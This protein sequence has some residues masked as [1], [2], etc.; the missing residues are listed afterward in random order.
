VWEYGQLAVG[1]DPLGDPAFLHFADHGREIAVWGTLTE[2]TADRFEELAKAAPALASVDLESQGGRI[3]EAQRIAQYV[4]NHHL[5]TRVQTDCES[6]C[7]LVLLAGQTRY[8][9]P[10]AKIGFHQPSF[11]G[12]TAEQQQAA[13]DANSRE[14]IAAGMD[15]Q[16]VERVM[17]TPPDNMWFPAHDE[18]VAANVING[19]PIVVGSDPSKDQ[20]GREISQAAA[21]IS[22]K[23]STRIDRITK[24]VGAQADGHSLILK[25]ALSEPVEVARAKKSMPDNLRAQVCNDEGSKELVAR[26]GRYVFRYMEP[27][28]KSFDLRVSACG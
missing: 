12:F 2:G 25:Y 1:H 16:F 28:G 9:D 27:S 3:L 4:R 19:D 15:E 22:A 10:E 13:I 8:A 18:L 20:L 21:Q 5:S 17:Q 26:G 6:A 23:G 11:P 7:T 24:L 14:Y